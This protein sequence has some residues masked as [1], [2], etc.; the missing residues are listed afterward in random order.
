MRGFLIE[1]QEHLMVIVRLG[2]SLQPHLYEAPL[3][4]AMSFDVSALPPV[5]PYPITLPPFH[6][7]SNASGTGLI[8]AAADSC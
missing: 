3:Y 2:K 5:L 1:E 6:A 8:Y 7:H 4:L